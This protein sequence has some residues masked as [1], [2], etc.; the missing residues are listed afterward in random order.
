MLLLWLALVCVVVIGGGIG[1]KLPLPDAVIWCALG[2]GVGFAPAI[3]NLRFDPN[4]S[5]LL[6][7]PPLVYS[8]AVR[9]PWPQFRD[10]LRPISLLAFGLVLVNTAVIALASHALTRLSWPAAI[11]LGAL[12]SPTDPVAASAV[13]ERVGL[14]ERIVA[15]LEGE[16]LVNDAVSLTVLR[17]AIAVAATGHVAVAAGVE[18]FVAIV[19]GE[20]I[21]GCV[22]G[23]VVLYLRRRIE[24]P[25]LEITVSLLTPFAAYLAPERLGGSGILATVAVGMYIG[26]RL[27]EVVP[28][29]TRLRSTSVWQ[30]VDFLLNGVL[31]VVA[32]IELR[33]VIRPEN[34]NENYLISG[35]LIAALAVCLRAAWCAGIWRLFRRHTVLREEDNRRMPA[36][37][38]MVIAWAGMRGPISLAAALS[39]PV[40]AKPAQL[41]HVDTLL[42]VTAVVI[43]VTLMV[44]GV[45]MPYVVRK[46]GVLRD[47]DRDRQEKARQLQIGAAE[48]AG[49]ALAKLAQMET[50]GGVPADVAARLRRFYR[51]RLDAATSDGELREI[52]AAL[53][54]V[55]RSCIRELRNDGRIS[56]QVRQELERKLDLRESG[57]AESQPGQ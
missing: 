40:L 3:R 27:S 5:L 41:G 8:A 46:V 42:F 9:L 1:R 31:F 14:P 38:M 52:R 22:V 54:G 20:P 24:D 55:E 35:L 10:N 19:I 57:L 28:A 43:V 30:I 29:G 56:D 33:R 32:G 13:A 7:L 12:I 39:V 45:G 44:Q 11:A 21:Y 36:R 15:I 26:E 34:L 50:E 17:I 16:G 51:D 49:A 23:A 6:L 18:R 37:H 25:R 2:F 53:I 4:L 47:A 48:A